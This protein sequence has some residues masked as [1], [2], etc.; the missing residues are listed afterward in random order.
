MA[1]MSQVISLLRFN[2]EQLSAQNAQHEF[3]HLCRH[4]ARHRICSNILPATG[5]VQ[6]GGDQGRDFET[7]RTYLASTP[8]SSSSFVGRIADGPMAFGCTLQKDG[9]AGKVKDDVTTMLASGTKIFA[10]HYFCAADV[11]VAK[12]HELEQWARDEKSIELSIHDGQAL[13]ENLAAP[14]TFWIAVEYLHVPSDILPR[15]EQLDDGYEEVLTKWKSQE[16]ELHSYADFEELRQLI[17]YAT[18]D[19]QARQDLPFWIDKVTE[20]LAPSAPRDLRRRAQY[21]VA[22]AR[23]RGQNSLH[24][25][26]AAIGRYFDEIDPID[27]L[28]QLEDCVLLLSFCLSGQAMGVAAFSLAD[29]KRWHQDLI[30][31]VEKELNDRTHPSTLANLLQ[32]RSSLSV[33]SVE[34]D[35]INFD[36]NEQFEWWAKLADILPDARLFHVQRFADTLAALCEHVGDHPRFTVISDRV[37]A[38]LADREGGYAVATQCRDRAFAHYRQGRILMAISEMHKTKI[39]WFTEESIEGCILSML[40]LSSWYTELGLAIAGKY[41]ALAACSVAIRQ[42]DHD[43]KARSWQALAEAAHCDYSLGAFAGFLNLAK[44]ATLL[45]AKFASEPG[46]LDQ[47]PV[48]KTIMFDASM[49]QYFTERLCPHYVDVYSQHVEELGIGQMFDECLEVIR[50]GNEDKSDDDLRAFWETQ[51]GAPPASD[52]GMTRTL[53]WRALDVEWRVTWTN[54]YEETRRAE[55]FIAC[56]QTIQAELVQYDLCIPKTSIAVSFMLHGGDKPKQTPVLTRE[57]YSWD[58]AWPKGAPEDMDA[59]FIEVVAA[60]VML[61][62]SAS[63][64]P[65]EHISEMLRTLQARGAPTKAMIGQS[66]ATVYADA[67]SEVEFNETRRVVGTLDEDS[68][69]APLK[70]V[71][72]PELEPVSGP[73]PGYSREATE[74]KIRE[75]HEQ[76]LK[77][78]P[79][80]IRRLKQQADFIAIVRVFKSRGWKDWHVLA[81]ILNFVLNY[82]ARERFGPTPTPDQVA[83]YM[84]DVATKPETKN[85]KLIPTAHFTMEALEFSRKMNLHPVLQSW[86]FEP[87]HPALRDEVIEDFL[88]RRYGYWDDDFEHEPIFGV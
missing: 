39:S 9:V 65:Q 69:G 35:G 82:R 18:T 8:L 31:R 56:L 70:R 44:I 33:H 16:A 77:L 54:L 26:E 62:G 72:H 22:V 43:A 15:N 38:V 3:E 66:Y 17:R 19:T 50:K 1:A 58:L 29:L 51:L 53:A 81:A 85:T 87:H 63:F 80:T 30:A 24:G 6:A 60:S 2:L 74:K 78:L 40:T 55:Q 42:S 73:G 34:S 59:A 27:S 52:I 21:E 61:L 25:H 79:F 14:E 68:A 4:Y 76:I 57:G 5:P 23:L 86:G 13:A 36:Q 41:Y 37:D 20:F 48:L 12:R 45:H 32:M 84:F 88:A 28:D 67:V 11:P 49:A 7:F 71:Q 47:N 64:R 83:K 10:V 75:R 46:N